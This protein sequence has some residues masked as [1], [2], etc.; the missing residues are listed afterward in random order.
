MREKRPSTLALQ[1]I[2]YWTPQDGQHF[3]DYD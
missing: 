1:P 2:G 3:Q